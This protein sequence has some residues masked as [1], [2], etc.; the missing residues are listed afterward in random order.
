[1]VEN[2]RTINPEEKVKIAIVGKYVKLEDS[3]ISVVESLQHAGFENKVKVEVE[4]VDSETIVP[5]NVKEKLSKFDGIVVPG[6]FG[7]RGIEGMIE[8]IKYVRENKIPFLGI[9][10]GMQMAV[11]EYARNV[12]GIKD[13]NSAEFSSNT[14]NPVIHIMETQKEI[15]KKGG[16]MRLGS[17]PCV[18]KEGS[19]ANEVYGTNKIDE[20]HRHR[21]EY[22]ND[23][24]ERLENAGLTCSGVSPDGSLV[25]IVELKEHPYFIAGQFHP[26]L[27]SRP[28]RPAPL[29]V[30]LIKAAK[31]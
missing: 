16:T 1:M 2:I 23:Y 3:Y 10:L 13:A 14:K 22:N 29:F 26:E 7:D 12:L 24:K 18:I 8:T 5:E 6:G 17:Y 9:C 25:E 31:K 19:L 28:N 20:R 15:K 11:I 21:F 30:G 27:K 4:M